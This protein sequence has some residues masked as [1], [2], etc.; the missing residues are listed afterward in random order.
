[1]AAP[2]IPLPRDQLPPNYQQDAICW[3]QHFK[4][5]ELLQQML[6]RFYFSETEIAAY[7]NR[8]ATWLKPKADSVGY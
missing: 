1:M 5:T 3:L 7:R 4:N 6:M 2:M 8:W